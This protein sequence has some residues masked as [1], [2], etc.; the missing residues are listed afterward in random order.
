M[1][2][3]IKQ[4]LIKA[5]DFIVN[6]K[7]KLLQLLKMVLSVLVVSGIVVLILFAFN[8]IYF[9]D[10]IQFNVEMFNTFKNSWY[11]WVILILFQIV[12]TTVLCFVPGV[13]MA[14]IMLMEAL[15]DYPWQ[16][17]LL[18]FVGVMLTSLMMYIVGRFG[19]YKLC[20]RFLGEDDCQKA[21]DLLNHRGVAFFP[22][23]MM[24]PVFPDDALVMIAGTLKMS[25]KWFV[26]SIV[27]GRGI[28]IA[29]ITF[30][31]SIVPFD[32]FT[33]I[34]HWLG[35]ILI[36]AAF[37]VTVFYLANRLNKYLYEKNFKAKEEEK[38]AALENSEAL[39]EVEAVTEEVTVESAEEAIEYAAEN[40]AEESV[41]EAKEEVAAA[42]DSK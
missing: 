37:I 6:K 7:D 3:K 17:F 27:I 33:T 8:V 38:K 20:A 35:F 24:F 9:E 15:F 40:A 11:G 26:P 42:T 23:M 25:L 14:F 32:K 16:A 36:C 1:K 2:Q 18:S 41:E 31:L 13:S 10:G 34:W 39:P 29:T 19:G 5:K 22:L 21:S 12:I 30:G 4:F 28:G